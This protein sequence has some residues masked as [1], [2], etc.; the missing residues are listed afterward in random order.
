MK[1]NSYLLAAIFVLCLPAAYA[2][3]P[4]V[5][6]LGTAKDCLSC[7][8]N[9]GPWQEEANTIIDILDKET[10][11]SLKQADGSFSLEFHPGETRTF[12]T[13]IGRV[14]GDDKAPPYRNAWLYIDPQ[15]IGGSALSK[16]PPGWEVNL[17]M[18]CRLVGDK[19]ALYEGAQ[20]TVLPMSIRPGGTAKDAEL[21]LQVMLTQGDAVK[22]KAKEGMIGNYF[23]R[24]VKLKI[25]K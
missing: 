10:Q 2:Y 4:A 17:P 23:E 24:K 5:G 6:I 15:T 9:N 3:P 19:I 18:A 8:L 7:H 25:L 13:V 12:L 21:A 1:K 22:G 11:K 16:F 20:V 14:K